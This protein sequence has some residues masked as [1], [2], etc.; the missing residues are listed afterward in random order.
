MA[1]IES[2]TLDLLQPSGFILLQ[3]R[4]WGSFFECTNLESSFA[5]GVSIMFII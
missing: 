4:F 3:A 1:A 2:S 5:S